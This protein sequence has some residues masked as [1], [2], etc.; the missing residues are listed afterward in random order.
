MTAT[1]HG[2]G[3]PTILF[4]PETALGNVTV[5]GAAR[6]ADIVREPDGTRLAFISPTGS[7]VYAVRVSPS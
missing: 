5:T 1:A 7:G 3:A 4:L 2:R 6:L